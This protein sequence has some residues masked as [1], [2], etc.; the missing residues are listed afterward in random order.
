MCIAIQTE[1]GKVVAADVL[2]RCYNSNPDGAGFAYI[3]DGKVELSKG[4][5]KIGEFIP[6]YHKIAEQ[7]GQD[8]AM[9][10]HFR[11]A[12]EGKVNAAN[13]HPFR[14]RNG[15][16][17]HNGCL[18]G[19]PQGLKAEFSDTRSFAQRMYNELTYPIVKAS[20]TELEDALGWNKLGLL[21]DDGSYIR[22]GD[23]YGEDG[24][25]YSNQ[26]Y[27]PWDAWNTNRS[28]SIVCDV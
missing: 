5:F 18:W 6:A 9:L 3:K 1:P 15:A 21:Y 20:I 2:V 16:L 11:I 25:W 13:T 24:V 7:Y 17:V 4:F 28:S 8:N 14:V 12:T 27:K 19:T 26:G 10:L 23:W 22:L